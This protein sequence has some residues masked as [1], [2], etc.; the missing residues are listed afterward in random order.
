MLFDRYKLFN[1]RSLA[2][3]LFKR[4]HTHFNDI[5]WSHKVAR[6]HAFQSTSSSKREDITSSLFNP[7][8]EEVRN[9]RRLGEWGVWYSEFDDWTRMS[10]V[11]AMAGYLET[12]IAQVTT[13]AFESAPS[14]IFGGGAM[15]D[16]AAFLKHNP[17]YDLYEHS[18]QFTRG[19]WQSRISAYKNFFGS[20]PFE[21]KLS[22]LEKLR[23][24][25]ND[26]GH[27]FGRDIKSMKFAQ[28]WEVKKLP[29]ISDKRLVIFLDLVEQVAESI[30]NHI[31]SK[32][33]GQYEI[34][35]VY[36]NWH[37]TME[38]KQMLLRGSKIYIKGFRKHF[39]KLT[40]SPYLAA[41]SLIEYYDNL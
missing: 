3:R 14:L 7:K 37:E 17:K 24:L 15:I 6:A 27:S 8:F 22:D 23:I 35:K 28:S 13:A 32:Y 19:S 5:Y 16:G 31:A 12:Y 41:R 40:S 20:C 34:I 11:M 36:H 18:E 9:S 10:A 38:A 33:V 29:K 30:D 1:K 21:S 2:H 4:H 39:S 26:V 25:R